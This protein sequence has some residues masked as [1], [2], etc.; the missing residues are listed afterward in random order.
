MGPGSPGN[1][2]PEAPLPAVTMGHK[3]T[4]KDF[5]SKIFKSFRGYTAI[6]RK[7]NLAVG[8]QNHSKNCTGQRNQILIDYVTRY[9]STIFN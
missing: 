8:Q 5:S 6:G 7:R 1:F 3:R 2:L 9:S 4:E